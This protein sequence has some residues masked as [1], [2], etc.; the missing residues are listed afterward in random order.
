MISKIQNHHKEK[1]AYVYIRQSTMGQVRFNQESTERQYALKEKALQLG[2][3]QRSIRILDQDLGKSGTQSSNRQDFKLLVADVS[4]NKVGAILSLEA[5]RLSRSNTDWHRLLE[6]CALTETLI[7][8]E[9]GCYNP[10]D[11]ND[12][13]LLGMKGTMSQAELHFIRARLLG[14]K[15]NK[16][17]KGELRF[18]LPVG[19]CYDDENRIVPDPDEEVRNA[20]TLL[21]S[22]FDETGSAYGV[23]KK[24][25]I[26]QLSFPKR[27]YGGVWNGKLIWGHLSHSRVLQ[28]L[29]NPSYAGVYAFGRYQ[30]KKSITHNGDVQSRSV[31]MPMD[32]W[33]VKIMEHHEGYISWE[34]FLNNQEILKKN[35]TNSEETI[36]SSAAREGKAILQGLLLCGNCGRRISVRYKGNGGKY[37]MYECNH[38]KR[39]GLS[40]NSCLSVRADI[41]DTGISDRILKIINTDQIKIALKAFENLAERENLMD[42]QWRMKIEK[43]EYEAQLAQRRYEEVDPSNRLVAETLEKRWETALNKVEE[44]KRQFDTHQQKTSIQINKVQKSKIMALAKNIPHLWSSSTTKEKD[45]KRILRLLIKDI[46]VERFSKEKKVILHIRWQGGAIEDLKLKL[47][48]MIYDRL[49]YS[50]EMISDVRELAKSSTDDEIAEIYNRKKML[51]STNRP[52]TKKMISWIRH[53]H[54]I[55]A[56]CL[57]RPEEYSVKQ[58][59]DQFGVSNHVVY[60]WIERGIVEARKIKNGLPYWITLDCEKEKELEAWVKNSK[61]LKVSTISNTDS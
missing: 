22:F 39:E 14:G 6:L 24:F 42:R 4:M 20:V 52:F 50:K 61:K 35:Q 23:V 11:F 30:S 7:I 55:P 38:L 2:W 27:S 17:K 43:A 59:C 29:K 57:K 25:G 36:M 21:F 28:M 51:S 58:V 46:T 19:L 44:A 8:D 13:L 48:P 3:S 40:G 45:R 5:S 33:K 15:L 47:P 37:A 26:S 60:Y 54:S 1:N 34:T 49:R 9:D 12:Q 32:E 31:K 41:L 53:K 10:S 16:A 56:P 18:P